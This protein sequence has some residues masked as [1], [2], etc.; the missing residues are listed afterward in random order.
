MIVVGFT[1]GQTASL[2]RTVTAEDVE[3]FAEASGDNN[4]VHLDEA[5]A[6]KSRFGKRIAHGMLSAGYIS[7]LLG[8]KFPGQGSIY[9]SQTLKFSRPVYIGDTIEVRARVT[10]YRADKKILTL[11]TEAVNQNGETVT[12]GEAVVLVS[13]VAGA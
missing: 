3:R 12:S 13:D 4:P 9:L 10:A 7:A 2:T 8:T 6:A 5:F 11:A 1:E